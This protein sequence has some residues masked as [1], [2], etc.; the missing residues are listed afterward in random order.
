MGSK[1]R[2]LIQQAKD[3]MGLSYE[4]RVFEVSLRK[5]ESSWCVL[6]GFKELGLDLSPEF[7]ELEK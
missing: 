5:L 6:E 4:T 7:E 1:Q 2:V 3:P